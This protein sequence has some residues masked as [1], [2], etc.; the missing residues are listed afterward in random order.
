[1]MMDIDLWECLPSES[2][3][4]NV[5][6][7]VEQEA[8]QILAVATDTTIISEP[9]DDCEYVAAVLL[10]SR[11]PTYTIHREAKL[12]ATV[13]PETSF[14]DVLNVVYQLSSSSID[15]PPAERSRDDLVTALT[16][17][18]DTIEEH[19][20]NIDDWAERH[21][22]ENGAMGT[23]VN[24][25]A[26]FTLYLRAERYRQNNQEPLRQ[27]NYK[28]IIDSTSIPGFPDRFILDDVAEEITESV[29]NWVVALQN[30]I[31]IA[32]NPSDF[33]GSVY[34]ELIP[35]EQRWRL[36]QFRTPTHLADLISELA[37][38]HPDETVLSP[39]VG[40]GS[41]LSAVSDAK[42][43]LGA[44]VP[45]ADIIGVDI[46]SMST[47]MG[48]VA[49]D[50]HETTGIPD[51]RTRDF[52]DVDPGDMP[53]VD[54]VVMNPPY[55]KHHELE[56]EEKRSLNNTSSSATGQSFSL[57]SPLYVYFTVHAS[58]FV[59]AGDRV[60]LLTPAEI[61]TTEYGQDWKQF[62]MDTF[63]IRGFILYDQNGKSQFSEANTTSLITVLDKPDSTTNQE[64]GTTFVKVT[65]EAA[66]DE[67][68]HCIDS[69]L[70]AESF[71]TQWGYVQ[72]IPQSSLNP[73]ND[74]DVHFDEDD[75]VVDD[76]LVTFNEIAT[77]NR[78]IATGQNSF[79]C[80]NDDERVGEASGESWVIEEKYLAPVI[81]KAQHVPYYDYREADWVDQRDRGLEVWLLYHL[82]NITWD[83]TYFEQE[84]SDETTTQQQLESTALD[85]SV[86]VGEQ[87]LTDEERRV[88]SYLKY[89]MRQSNPP[90]ETHL[91]Q[92]RVNWYEVE[93]K[94]SP[95]VVYTSMS[96]GRGR[97]VY[98]QMRAKNLN[99][100]HGIYFTVDLNDQ[101]IKALLAYLNSDFVDTIVKRNGRTL[102]T[103]M[104][105]V[106]PGDLKHIPVI[107]PRTLDSKRVD[108]LATLFDELCDAA[109]SDDEQPVLD[110]I[111]TELESFLRIS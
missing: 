72:S 83:S 107:D 9:V 1:M 35:Q 76:Q 71:D 45:L 62:L 84:I 13:L 43:E 20:V 46:S 49:F 23:V 32:D 97:F 54:C 31:T 94:P 11:V 92:R 106:E 75:I 34:E 65:D 47:L 96:R 4:R 52:F 79:F 91:A 109:R 16:I 63:A 103:G 42:H 37:V 86:N 87:Y 101:E 41:I 44:D 8:N 56:P 59:D 78:G 99:N 102:S 67:L 33:I 24:R 5:P 30:Y 111:T 6:Q 69:E 88:V 82:D 81:R 3:L 80:L 12:A 21:G 57:L 73:T 29:F 27:D 38:E 2:F 110:K 28:R 85:S 18:A 51:I 22:F 10:A 74:W 77:V 105:K 64:H 66:I 26:V 7:V 25:Q 40:A 48:G 50:A 53:N 60:V 15:T 70:P 100:M 55:T 58:T 98:N 89:G 61:L 68:V 93:R 90:H 36:G 17:A 14:K 19:D 95:D 104:S 108:R 39:G